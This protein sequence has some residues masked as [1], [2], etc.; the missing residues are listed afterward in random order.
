MNMEETDE[1]TCDITTIRALIDRMA[2]LRGDDAFLISPETK[3][4]LTFEALQRRAIKLAGQMVNLGL[5]RG[6]KVSMM[7]D[8]G[9]FTAELVLAALYGGFVAVPLNVGAGASEV[10]YILSHSGSVLIFVS[11]D[12]KDLVQAAIRKAQRKIK[13]VPVH[14]DHDVARSALKADVPALP[15]LDKEDD[16]LLMYTSGSTSQPKGVVLSHYN[17]IA[18]G[19][20]TIRAHGLSA[21]DRLLCVLPLY[22]MNA[23]VTLIATLL[24]GGTLVIPRGFNV[25]AFW[26]WIADY[27]C[28]WSS[29]VPTIISHLMNWT[30]ADDQ[31]EQIA[32]RHLRF[33]RSSSAP[34]APSQ[35]R[36][37][38]DRFN[39]TLI[40]AMGST[41]AGGKFFINPLPPRQRKIG[42]PG[43]PQGFESKIVDGQGR[44][45]IPGQSGEIWIRGPSVMKGYYKNSQATAE[46]LTADGW[47]RTG[48]LGYRDA[49]GYFFIVGRAKEIIIK[50]GENIAP[51]EIDEALERYPAVMEA[52]AVGIP[53]PYMGEDIV[54]YVILKPNH[55]CSEP[56]LLAFCQT[57]LGNLKTP[58]RIYFVDELPKG[59]S[60]K[61]QRLRLVQE[62]DRKITSRTNTEREGS[63]AV[64][65]EAAQPNHSAVPQ[66]GAIEREIRRMWCEVLQLNRVSLH[67]NFFDLGGQS[68]KASQVISRIREVFQ[69]AMSLRQL[70]EAPTIAGLA[71]RIEIALSGREAAS[72]KISGN[73]ERVDL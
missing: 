4:E 65:A 19:C 27:R 49:D 16:A 22:H 7:L 28:T 32:R 38:E 6:E 48:D 56:E 70:F 37:F 72:R 62:T 41:E 24:S 52:A 2:K 10:E 17:I 44:E 35:H 69:L 20:S 15:D 13:V 31:A 45:V 39:V 8:N 59:P 43:V 60:G 11:D 46:V 68:I 55:H 54:A 58:S 51:R 63:R 61:L 21:Q 53:D 71:E 30:S 23:Q 66:R 57:Q 33:L 42:S 1:F 14:W 40:E 73:R 67:D 25:S 3:R 34:L 26:R 5:S 9:V 47:L 12:H 64:L 18:N 36:A 29:I 50:G